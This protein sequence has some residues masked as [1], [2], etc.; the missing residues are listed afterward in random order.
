MDSPYQ[1]IFNIL[2]IYYE[3][4]SFLKNILD[5]YIKK[6][7]IK[8]TEVITDYAY[9]IVRN[10]IYLTHLI[11]QFVKKIKNKDL[12]YIKILFYS[13][14]FRNNIK[15]EVFINDFIRFIKKKFDVK[16]GG[17]Y[18][19]VAR[20][21]LRNDDVIDKI[22]KNKQIYYSIPMHL[23]NYIEKN[24]DDK[25]LKSKIYDKMIEVPNF[26]F[27][28]NK[29]KNGEEKFQKN[30][31]WNNIYRLD[32]TLKISSIINELK[33]QEIT[34]QDISSQMIAYILKPKENEY[35]ADFCSAPGG[36]STL[37]SE[38]TENKANILSIELDEKR[39]YRLKENI[40]NYKNITP[41]LA[42]ATKEI[43]INDKKQ[44]FD[45]ILVDAPCS[46]LGTISKSPDKKYRFSDINLNEYTKIQVDILNNALN[47]LKV[48]GELVYSLCTFT[49]EECIE[50]VNI[51]LEKNKG[52]VELMDFETPDKKFK[53][54]K[55]F[56]ANYYDGDLFFI[57]KFKKIKSSDLI[58]N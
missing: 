6:N 34:I 10:D 29:L 51:F 30:H 17:F 40:I 7:Q 9:G 58:K 45:K 33:N 18:N 3:E 37:L 32:K 57:T 22:K 42:D 55:L 43:I 20:N 4:N 25:D 24:I 48:G 47:H 14:I 38:L 35:I 26:Y 54:N 31:I 15:K 5:I 39:F 49:K 8:E 13:L 27:R 53:G 52:I 36:K 16:K 11:K 56:T 1:D 21:L 41:L 46:A 19:G 12:I 2:K 23:Y 44:V 28:V 50:S